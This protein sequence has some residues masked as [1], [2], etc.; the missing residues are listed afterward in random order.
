ME[1][2][3]RPFNWNNDNL[4]IELGHGNHIVKDINDCFNNNKIENHLNDLL[5][6]YFSFVN[7]SK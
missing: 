1:L 5:K 7:D 3:L 2:R 6:S 4:L